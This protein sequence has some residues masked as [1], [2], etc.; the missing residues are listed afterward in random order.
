MAKQ[1]EGQTIHKI[2]EKCKCDFLVCEKLLLFL[3]DIL[4][5][6]KGSIRKGN[7]VRL[8]PKLNQYAY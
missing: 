4:V 6:E 1:I 5:S 2:I 8:I 7:A 3:C